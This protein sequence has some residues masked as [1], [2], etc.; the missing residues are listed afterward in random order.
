MPV[1]FPPLPFQLD[2]VKRWCADEGVTSLPA[3]PETVSAYLVARMKEGLKASSLAV[4]VAAI[5]HSHKAAG[6]PTP[7][8]HEAVAMVMKGI[9][10]TIGTAPVQKQPAT[11]SGFPRCWHTAA[12]TCTASAT[13][14][15]S[16]PALS[17]ARS[18]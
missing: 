7:T 12:G 9:R 17:A 1:V 14:H 13:A 18:R 6:L 15:Y 5:R 4:A 3:E 8:E 2:R 11:P 16:P 10:R